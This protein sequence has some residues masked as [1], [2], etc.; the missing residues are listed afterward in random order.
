MAVV[1][2]G[3][4]RLARAIREKLGAGARLFVVE[5]R[6]G[7]HKYLGDFDDVEAD[8]WRV[9]AF[10]TE[11]QRHGLFDLL[12]FYGLHE[13]WRG[14][15]RRFQQLL[16]LSKPKGTLWVTF[17]NSSA[18][19]YLEKELPPLRLAADAL[20][21]PSRFWSR[22]DYASWIACGAML[23]TCIESVW[24]LFD[25][26]SFQYCENPTKAQMAEWEI[27]GVK[28][29]A[30]TP[31]EIVHWGAAYVGIQMVVQ[32]DPRLDDVAQ[33][34]GGVAFNPHLFQSLVDPFPEVGNEESALAWA[35]TELRTLRA[36]RD[37]LRPSQL[38][39]FMLGLVDESESVR[40]V[41]VLGA[42]W[43]RDVYFLKKA[44]PLWNCTGVELSKEL[45]SIGSVLCH[46]EGIR[47]EPFSLGDKLPFADKS[48][49]VILSFGFMSK[50][51]DQAALPLVKE[52]LRVG[53][54]Q[55]YQLEDSR[56]PE[57]A[58]KLKLN[59]LPSIYAQFE[60]GAEPKPVLIQG[61]NSGF[62]FYKVTI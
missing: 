16:E 3:D 12:I 18:L 43:G 60:R 35:E 62:I 39:E 33:A 23:N 25:H 7:L 15:F 58:P 24:G 37:S 6:V 31:V 46:E 17:V 49:D 20:A 53:R 27:R 4:G 51:Y 19:R 36:S 1:G 54:K 29:Q 9:E 56:G 40:D 5:H 13:Y 14:Q 44:R 41:L 59:S 34:M 21:A 55:I 38:I 47:V 10:A 32:P 26:A 45:I 61:K 2:D 30:R 48:F 50:L 52:L 28:V 11:A 42:G 22:V 57:E 8:P